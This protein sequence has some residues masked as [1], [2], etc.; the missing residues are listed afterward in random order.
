MRGY[1]SMLPMVG[2]VNEKQHEYVDKIMTGIDQMSK[3]VD[4]L[5]DLSRIEAGIDF[6]QDEIA[7]HPLLSD[8]AEQYWQHAHLAGIK[9]HVDVTPKTTKVRGDE[10][11]IRQAITNLVGNGI[12]YAK[13]SGSMMLGAS[14]KNGKVIIS[15]KDN[16]PGIPEENQ[17]RLFEKFYRVK[18]PGQEKIK[19]TGLGLAIVKTIAERHGGTVRCHSKQGEGSTFFIELPSLSYTNGSTANGAN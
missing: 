3:L 18:S 14:V 13:N 10:Q 8:I 17:I 12:K 4:D 9:L 11:L 5:L 2:E 16:G 1:I 6:N 19:G 15:V 7:L